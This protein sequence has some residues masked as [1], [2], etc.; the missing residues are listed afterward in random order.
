MWKLSLNAFRDHCGFVYKVQS[1][2][3]IFTQCS[4]IISNGTA[5]ENLLAIIRP[6]LKRLIFDLAL[7]L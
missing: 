5:K 6:I 3:K 7:L 2:S 1:H 4:K